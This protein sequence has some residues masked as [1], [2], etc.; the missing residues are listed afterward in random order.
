MSLGQLFNTAANMAGAF[1][2]EKGPGKSLK[3]F[4]GAISNYGVQIKSNYE[5]VYSGFGGISFFVQ[6][7]NVPGIKANTGTLYWKGRQV[8]IPINSEQEHE[9]QM[10]I[11]ND[12][13]GFIYNQMRRILEI[14]ARKALGE[15]DA[16][17]KVRAL[18]DGV[19][20]SGQ[21]FRFYGA[22]LTQVSGLDFASTDSSI[23]TFTTTWYVSRTVLKWSETK[24]KDGLLGKVDKVSGFVSNILG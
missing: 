11:I 22:L 15:A 7:I 8:T 4:L 16:E 18:G 13:T 19:N 2:G 14:D 6:S 17:I 9:V 5:V 12:G 20:T 24:R 3:D 23:S 1:G 21:K 10:T